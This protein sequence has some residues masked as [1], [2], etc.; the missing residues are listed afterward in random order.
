[1]GEMGTNLHG[2]DCFIFCDSGKG[3]WPDTKGEALPNLI[4]AEREEE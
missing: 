2:Q 3:L 4:G 1:M